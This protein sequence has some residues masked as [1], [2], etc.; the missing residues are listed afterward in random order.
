V[1]GVTSISGNLFFNEGS[2]GSAIMACYITGNVRIGDGGATVDNILVRCCNLNSVQVHNNTCEGIEINQNYIRDRSNFNFASVTIK[3]NIIHSIGNVEGGV[4]SYNFFVSY[5]DAYQGGSLY[6]IKSSVV[7]NNCTNMGDF[8]TFENTST[9]EN[10]GLTDHVGDYCIFLGENPNWNDVFVNYNNRTISPESDFHFKEPYKQYESQ[11]GIYAGDGFN[12]SHPPVPY[13][14][15]K[16]IDEQ[17][18]A[19]GKLS[20]KIRVKAGGEEE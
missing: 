10:L 6:N 18:D 9:F 1:D 7:N 8:G 3:N 20:V 5:F 12:D 13:I 15:A 4:I 11:V 16:R 14:V 17:T 19:S 2:S